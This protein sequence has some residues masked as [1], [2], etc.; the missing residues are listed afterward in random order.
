MKKILVL[1][2]H[3]AYAVIAEGAMF[4]LVTTALLCI[5]SF[6]AKPLIGQLHAPWVSCWSQSGEQWE[7]PKTVRTPLITS[8]DGN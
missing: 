7:G 5:L 8:S 4:R 1:V 2:D 6:A 3:K